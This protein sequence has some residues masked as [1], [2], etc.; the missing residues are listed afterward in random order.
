MGTAST[1]PFQMEVPHFRNSGQSD[2]KI[3]KKSGKSGKKLKLMLD[4]LAHD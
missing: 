4:F 1:V 2:S 3:Q